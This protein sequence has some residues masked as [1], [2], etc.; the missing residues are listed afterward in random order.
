M[1]TKRTFMNNTERFFLFENNELTEE[2]KQELNTDFIM[3]PDLKTEY[4]VYR[5]VNDFLKRNHENLKIKFANF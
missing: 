4:K 1:K 2:E 3:Y 5:E